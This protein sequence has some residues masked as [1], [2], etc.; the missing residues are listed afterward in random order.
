MND[1][2]NI[3]YDNI[4][5]N[6]LIVSTSKLFDTYYQDSVILIFKHDDQGAK[7]IILNH[8]T[9]E[10][11]IEYFYHLGEKWSNKEHPF[12]VSGGLIQSENGFVIYLSE[13]K[14]PQWP[15][16]HIHE[17]LYL[18]SSKSILRSI[19]N[20]TGPSI[21]TMA[22][23]HTIWPAEKLEEE[24][25]NDLWLIVPIDENIIFTRDANIM[26]QRAY[27]KLNI[28]QPHNYISTHYED[29]V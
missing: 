13:E 17:N 10:I 23:G 19:A 4:F 24:I 2:D 5:G 27:Q 11:S 6:K 14:Q 20:N 25:K 29:V 8:I 28:L 26:L 21:Y 12:I 9:A 16:I 1:K 18:C 22:L 3:V 7:G 15:S